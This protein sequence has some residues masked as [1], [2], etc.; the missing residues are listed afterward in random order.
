[1]SR[2]LLVGAGHAHLA[3]LHALARQPLAGVELALVS[4][5]ARQAYSGMLPGV[6]A[7][8][9][10]RSEAEIDVARL[11]AA[12]GARFIEG[13]V[14]RFDAA[15]R[16]ALLKGGETLVFDG[17]SLNVGSMPSAAV[18]GA[19][20]HALAAKPFEPFLERLR[21][22]PGTHIA[23]I[24]AGAAGVELAMAMRHRGA[25]VSIYSEQPAFPKH[26]AARV[27][28]ALRRQSVNFLSM[29]VTGIEP[30][31]TVVA[32]TA[33]ARYDG[34][35]LATGAVPLAWLARSGLAVDERG[36]VLV[37]RSLRSVSHPEVFAVGDCATVRDAPHPRSGVYSVR[38]GA[39][40]AENLRRLA[41]GEPLKGYRPQRR[42]LVLISCGRR[43][44]IAQR[45]GWSAEGWWV[46]RWKD[47]IDRRWVRRLNR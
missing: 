37:E 33:Q 28:A 42:A 23:V 20:E 15:R 18:P 19:A 38:Q 8:H 5:F 3:L 30:G 21:L 39:L 27:G 32:G 29:A 6:I 12:A 11:A 17:A 40:L 16:E 14:T 25:L 35:V 24:G 7:G 36:F 10:R 41:R 1:M 22:P 2:I 31:P 34:V 43:Y 46:W 13:E 47:W 45:G 9:Y 4:P 44:A 26:V